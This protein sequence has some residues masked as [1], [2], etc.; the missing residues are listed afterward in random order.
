[1]NKRQRKKEM[2][3]W[4]ETVIFIED[5]THLY[6]PIDVGLG[7]WREGILEMQRAIAA[8]FQ[9]PPWMLFGHRLG[10]FEPPQLLLGWD[11]PRT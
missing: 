6:A 4:R 5:E 3:K 8:A 11:G 10:G 2:K 1:M 7:S 9:A